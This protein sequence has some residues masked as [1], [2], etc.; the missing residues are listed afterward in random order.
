MHNQGNRSVNAPREV[1]RRGFL[2]GGVVGGLAYAA[3]GLSGRV[4]AD[5]SVVPS[6]PSILRLAPTLEGQSSPVITA[7]AI[8]PSGRYA[9]AAGDDHAI[10][11]FD[12]QAKVDPYVDALMLESHEDWVQALEISKDG[13]WLG[14]CGKDG[15]LQVWRRE[16]GPRA[17]WKRVHVQRVEH[18]FFAIKFIGEHSLVAAGFSNALYR[19]DLDQMQWSID[20][21]S[22][23]ADIR[24]IAIS[25]DQR[26]LAYGGRD[27]AVRL[28]ELDR[29][30]MVQ[31]RKR[32][33]VMEVQAHT[34]RIRAIVFSGDD[35]LIYSVGEDRRMIGIDR[36]SESIEYQ[37]DVGAG[38]LMAIERL[39]DER[40]ALS[41]SDNTIRVVE[42]T[43]SSLQGRALQV[44]QT[45]RESASLEARSGIVRKLAGRCKL[46]GHD[47]TIAVL[48]SHGNRLYSGSFDT[49]IRTWN[50]SDALMQLDDEGRFVHPVSARFENS[51]A[52]ERIR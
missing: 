37:L 28:L 3:W 18:A 49:T 34:N 46:I 35:T 10:R 5:D 9:V 21:E 22:P 47:G 32:D 33:S 43:R 39:S 29:V 41:G 14:S 4:V 42:P 13:R 38:R 30:P 48:R 50:I 11:W 16:D 31:D 45:T 1:A 51:G 7:L 40:Y 52:Q 20:H 44:S 23:C 6:V 19:L 17:G 8:D 24:A 15:L 27:G 2:R 12:L 36:K 25:N 26:I